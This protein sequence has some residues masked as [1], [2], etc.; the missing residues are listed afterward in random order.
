MDAILGRRELNN[1]SVMTENRGKESA[2]RHLRRYG[3]ELSLARIIMD[4]LEE[5]EQVLVYPHKLEILYSNKTAE[6][7]KRPL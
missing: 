6:T 1:L 3:L 7:F 5:I 4:K 2:E